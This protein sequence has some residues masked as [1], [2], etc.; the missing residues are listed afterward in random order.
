MYMFNSD[1]ERLNKDSSLHFLWT[2]MSG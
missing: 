1:Y 2:F